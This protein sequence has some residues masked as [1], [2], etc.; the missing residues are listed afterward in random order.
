MLRTQLGACL[1]AGRDIRDTQQSGERH[2]GWH[3]GAD[4][5]ESNVVVDVVADEQNEIR[6]T[7][8][9]LARQVVVIR[10]T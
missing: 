3:V 4:L 10:P 8:T 6:S 9:K 7:S 5:G 2:E 1:P